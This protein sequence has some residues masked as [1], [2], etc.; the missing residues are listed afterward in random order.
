MTRITLKDSKAFGLLKNK[1]IE[2]VSYQRKLRKEW[3][4]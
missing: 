1:K 4:K 2:G 3:R